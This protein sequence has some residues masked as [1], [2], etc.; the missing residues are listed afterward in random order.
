LGAV[1]KSILNPLKKTCSWNAVD[2][3]A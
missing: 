3:N 1:G 2:W